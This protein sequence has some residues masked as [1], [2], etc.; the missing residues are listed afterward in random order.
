MIHQPCLIK[1]LSTDALCTLS[2]SNSVIADGEPS[3][4]C[5]TLNHRVE[6]MTLRGPKSQFVAEYTEKKWGAKYKKNIK[7]IQLSKEVPLMNTQK[8]NTEKKQTKYSI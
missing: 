8:N 4:P 2:I 3:S 5:L 7:K 1:P 6:C